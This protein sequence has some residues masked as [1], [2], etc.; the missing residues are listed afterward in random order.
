M[1]KVVEDL[2]VQ[3]NGRDFMVHDENGFI[4]IDFAS[5]NAVTITIA[6]GGTEEEAGSAAE[7]ASLIARA[8]G[9]EIYDPQ[10]KKVVPPG[11]LKSIVRSWRSNDVGVLR[12]YA[13]GRHFVRRLGDDGQG[14]LVMIEAERFEE[15]SASGYA[16]VAVAFMRINEYGEAVDLFKK[17]LASEPDNVNVLYSLGLAYSNMGKPKKALESLRR[18]AALA[19]DNEMVQTLLLDLEK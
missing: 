7:L 19:P 13:D 9:G 17:A 2:N 4:A 3:P 12:R 18:A 16:S 5:E 6:F 14:R 10:L 1:R 8:S 11:D 15:K